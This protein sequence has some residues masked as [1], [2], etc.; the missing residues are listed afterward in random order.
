MPHRPRETERRSRVIFF[1]LELKVRQ[2]TSFFFSFTAVLAA[3]G[4]SWAGGRITVAAEAYASTTVTPDLSRICDLR[5][6]LWQC[7]ILTP[8]SK[9]RGQTCTLTE[10]MLGP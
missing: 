7:R 4:S 8:L 6:S 3:K 5:P 2:L 1:T 10:T 9:A